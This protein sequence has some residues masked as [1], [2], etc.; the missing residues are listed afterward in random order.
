M[1]W[2][3][4]GLA[5]CGKNTFIPETIR[6]H[7][8]IS[9]HYRP[10]DEGQIYYSTSGL[11]WCTAILSL[12]SSII[13]R[14]PRIISCQ[15]K[16]D[17]LILDILEKNGVQI[18][19]ITT[20]YIAMIAM[21]LESRSAD[22]TKLR[23][24]QTG[25]SPVSDTLRQNIL[26]KVP[27][28]QLHTVYG[29]T[30]AGG[31]IALTNNTSNNQSNSVGSLFFGIQAKV[32]SGLHSSIAEFCTEYFSQL[33]ILKFVL[34]FCFCEQISSVLRIVQNLFIQTC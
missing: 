23:S 34:I 20:V 22:L 10:L 21:R 29:I 16:T 15:P 8:F 24:I 14:S 25:G 3:C 19:Y 4:L 18:V 31:V 7:L 32:T 30:D 13:F 11:N 27:S 6:Q 28:A 26:S 33:I 12:G 17:D 1:H 9:L 5:E 2:Q